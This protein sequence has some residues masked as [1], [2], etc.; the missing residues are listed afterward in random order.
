MRILVVGPFGTIQRESAI[1]RGFRECGCEV[2][3]CGYGDLVFSRH[4]LTRIQFRLGHGPVFRTLTNRI[5]SQ[6]CATKPD[7]IF[8]RRPLEFS[9]SMLHEIRSS[10]PAIFASFN[11]DDPFSVSY[12]DRRWGSLRAAIPQFDVHF[13]FRSRNIEEFF[14]AGAKQVALWEP[15]YTPWIHRPIADETQ[16]LSDH[17]KILFAMH[18]EADERRQFVLQL[19]DGGFDV[20]I[21]S[22]NWDA[23]F[24]KPESVRLGV[25][26]HL[27]GDDYVRAIGEASATLC[28]FSKQNNDELT[29][30]VFEI[31]ACGG[32]LLSSRTSRLLQ[33]F[34]DKEEAFFFSSVDELLKI[35]A[36]LSS[37]PALVIDVKRRGYE[38]LM[39]S[40]HSIVDRCA[41]SINVL[42]RLM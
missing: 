39:K 10:Y 25:R 9:K 22:W 33:I 5:I 16:I 28:F 29:S 12:T 32:L 37:D 15:F 24:G 6:A 38:R 2:F 11:N 1:V 31:P 17:F 30:R 8:F 26:P 14:S 7:V 4:L 34:R 42:Q 18:A 27:L 13:A 23:L 40:R 36:L 20:N 21:H 35:V 3:E 41:D 19:I